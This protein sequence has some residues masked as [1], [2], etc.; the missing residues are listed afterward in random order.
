MSVYVVDG[1]R[2]RNEI[3][4]DFTCGGNGAVYPWTPLRE[5]WIDQNL[6]PLDATATLLHEYVEFRHMTRRGLSYEQAH[7]IATAIEAEFRSTHASAD[8]RRVDFQLVKDALTRVD[9][10]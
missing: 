2:I 9:V 1:E 6:S 3:F 10:P 7:D 8:L 4:T 5:L